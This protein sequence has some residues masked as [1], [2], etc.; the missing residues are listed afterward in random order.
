MCHIDCKCHL[1]DPGTELHTEYE[2]LEE[3]ECNT[4]CIVEQEN[5]LAESSLL[6]GSFPSSFIATP[7]VL[8]SMLDS[9]NG[10]TADLSR[11]YCELSSYVCSFSAINLDPSL[12]EYEIGSAVYKSEYTMGKTIIG[13][14]LP[15]N[16]SDY[17]SYN[18]TSRF[19]HLVSSNLREEYGKVEIKYPRRYIKQDG[20]DFCLRNLPNVCDA[21]YGMSKNIFDI[22]CSNIGRY[23]VVPQDPTTAAPSTT[24]LT[25]STEI[26]IPSTTAAA[27][28][29]AIL[30]TSVPYTNS[31]SSTLILADVNKNFTTL[32]S[33]TFS[34]TKTASVTNNISVFIAVLV[35]FL[36]L[37]VIILSFGIYRNCISKKDR[38]PQTNGSQVD[39][40]SEE[41]EDLV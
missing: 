18:D 15:I 39:N 27:S 38:R 26:S 37:A 10:Y 35:A 23:V 21:G 20:N 16:I 34:P 29:T 19:L 25:S 1:Q 6:A 9:T 33:V 8:L 7:L 14:N 24:T 30:S 13:R 36:L 4:V 28:T 22:C 32:E 31:D 2:G 11:H 3:S 17:I 40:I 5:H 12:I 41:S